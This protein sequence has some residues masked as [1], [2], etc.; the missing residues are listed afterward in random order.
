MAKEREKQVSQFKLNLLSKLHLAPEA[1]NEEAK[2]PYNGGRF[3]RFSHIYTWKS[4]RW[5]S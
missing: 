4:A 2:G 1:R 5:T 3:K